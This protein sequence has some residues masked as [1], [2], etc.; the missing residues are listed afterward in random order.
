M[1]AQY[2][3]G[4][5]P[6]SNLRDPELLEGI[7]DELKSDASSDIRRDHVIKQR[8]IIAWDNK[9]VDIS[10]DPYFRG[11][12]QKG[13]LVEYLRP[14]VGNERSFCNI[15]IARVWLSPEEDFRDKN[16]MV[17]VFLVHEDFGRRVILGKI[18]NDRKGNPK[19]IKFEPAGEEQFSK[20]SKGFL[21]VETEGLGTLGKLE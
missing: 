13:S 16:E 12:K 17:L 21:S 9:V 8:L 18:K 15:M 20:I 5:F 3:N 1:L 7:I 19:K 14:F 6:G 10:L 2:I 4:E 11:A